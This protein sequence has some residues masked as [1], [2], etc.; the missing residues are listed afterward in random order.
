[1]EEATGLVM[2][3]QRMMPHYAMRLMNLLCMMRIINIVMHDAYDDIYVTKTGTGSA[4]IGNWEDDMI[5]TSPC[6]ESAF[7]MKR[8]TVRDIW[9]LDMQFPH[10]MVP[11]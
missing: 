8:G 2:Q 6:D 5:V 11:H 3:C 4:L 10:H 9:I 1:M 7:G